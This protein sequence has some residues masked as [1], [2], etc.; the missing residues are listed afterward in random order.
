V[1]RSRL[2]RNLEVERFTELTCRPTSPESAPRCRLGAV[3]R[4]LQRSQMGTV[5]P[6]R[7][8]YALT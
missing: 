5:A 8:P 6:I 2:L 3:I 7:V 1:L 4:H